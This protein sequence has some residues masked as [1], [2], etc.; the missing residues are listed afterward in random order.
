MVH[1]GVV[2]A[3]MKL[4]LYAVL[5]GVGALGCMVGAINFTASTIRN[6]EEWKAI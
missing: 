5:L 2:F 1:A 4:W 3:F 6:S